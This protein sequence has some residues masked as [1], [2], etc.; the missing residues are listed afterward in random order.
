MPSYN[1]SC[2]KCEHTTELMRTISKRNDPL[3]C[4]KCGGDMLKL[5]GTGGGIIFRG[6]GFFCTTYRRDKVA[7]VDD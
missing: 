2:E 7:G 3:K 6:E 1:Y 5:I 4:E